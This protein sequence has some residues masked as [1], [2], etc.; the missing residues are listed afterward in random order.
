[1]KTQIKG[2]VVHDGKG[3]QF[4]TLQDALAHDTK[5]GCGINCKK[6]YLVLPNFNS[7]SG[8]GDQ[9]MAI[10]VVNGSIEI[11]T[12]ANVEAILAGYCVDPEVSATSVSISGCLPA[13]PLVALCSCSNSFRWRISYSSCNWIC[14]N[15]IHI[16]RWRIYSNLC[17]NCT[18][19]SLT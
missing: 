14:Y 19:L 11:D 4:T 13:T 6:G 18:S 9:F 8:D 7:I 17:Y 12:V 16:N 3:K 15:Y 2:G 1:M 5:C 10:Y